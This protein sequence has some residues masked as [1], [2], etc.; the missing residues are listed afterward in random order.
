MFVVLSLEALNLRHKGSRMR[1]LPIDAVRYY[2]CD[3]SIMETDDA[4]VGTADAT[5]EMVSY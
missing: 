1:F 3:A 4:I 5:S 2:F